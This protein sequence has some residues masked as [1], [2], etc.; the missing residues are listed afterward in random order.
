LRAEVGFTQTPLRAL[1][2]P[3]GTATKE[4]LAANTAAATAR[5]IPPALAFIRAG[6]ELC[7]QK[8]LLVERLP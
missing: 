7:A 8:P 6:F 4:R 5:R 1:A 2:L 3:T